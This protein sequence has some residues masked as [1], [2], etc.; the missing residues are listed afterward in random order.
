LS[1]QAREVERSNRLT[2]REKKEKSYIQEL[3]NNDAPVV[4]TSDYTRAYP[5]LIS[6][7]LPNLFIALGTDGFGRSDTRENLRNF[8]EIDKYH[9]VIA[10]LDA[11]CDQGLIAKSVLQ[12]TLKKYNINSNSEHPWSK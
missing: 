4:A 8:F 10:T 7:Y 12:A 11:L 9:L 2:G 3:I 1:K 5:Q 6:S